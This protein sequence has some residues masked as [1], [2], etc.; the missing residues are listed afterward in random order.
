MKSGR[1]EQAKILWRTSVTRVDWCDPCVQSI[2]GYVTGVSSTLIITVR[3][4]TTALAFGTGKY[5]ISYLESLI[6]IRY[7]ILCYSILSDVY[8]VIKTLVIHECHCKNEIIM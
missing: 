6:N 1:P 2:V 4:S 3:T 7:C 8:R 5:V